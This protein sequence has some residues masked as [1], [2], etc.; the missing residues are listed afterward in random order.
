V[1]IELVHI[2]IVS[3]NPDDFPYDLLYV[4]VIRIFLG[5]RKKTG[6]NVSKNREYIKN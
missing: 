2:T 4:K 6:E 3:V 1:I 5:I